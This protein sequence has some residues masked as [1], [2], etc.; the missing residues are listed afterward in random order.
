MGLVDLLKYNENNTTE[1]KDL[2]E[3]I[4]NSAEDLDAV[5]RNIAQKTYYK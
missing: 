2:L 1:T 3:N 4:L 5:I